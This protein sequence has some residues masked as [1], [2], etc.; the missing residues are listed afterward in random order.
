M[1]VALH[2]RRNT[3][4]AK[5]LTERQHLTLKVESLND[6]EVEDVMEYISNIEAL[7]RSAISP[8][9]PEDEMIALLADAHE[10]RRARQA[11]EWE[12]ARRRAS[13]L[14]LSRI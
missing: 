6:T 4:M 11:F 14:P 5:R 13:A 3:V 2:R 8:G 7:Q 12:A 9:I 10:N 1:A